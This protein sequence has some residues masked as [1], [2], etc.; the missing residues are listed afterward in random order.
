MLI[1]ECAP[2][3]LETDAEVVRLI[4]TLAALLGGL[5]ALAPATVAVQGTG[6]HV[7]VAGRDIVRTER[8]I[9]RNAITPDESHL[10]PTECAE[11]RRVIAEVADRM[12]DDSG[13]PNFAA[14]HRMLQRRFEVASYLL[15]PRELFVDALAFLKQLRGRYRRAL[16]RRNPSA[17]ANDFFR[18]IH[19]CSRQLGWDRSRLCEFAGDRLGLREP[20]VSLRELGP[21]QLRTLAEV[22][23]RKTA[24]VSA[25]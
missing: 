8:H 1:E 2:A 4:Q 9:V 14:V 18:V 13:A 17:Y 22:L 19:A 16:R 5:G 24:S 15:I 11:I 3:K 25:V 23:R 12:A 20:V 6:N 10:N 21:N 7:E